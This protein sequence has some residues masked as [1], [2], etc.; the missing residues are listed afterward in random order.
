M[1]YT[2]NYTINLVPGGEMPVVNTSC[3]DTARTIAFTLMNGRQAAVI[4]SGVTATCDGTK[5]DNHSFTVPCTI[6]S[7]IINVALTE[8]M[9][10]IPGDVICQI[11]LHDGDDVIGTANF[12]LRVENAAVS[13]DADY[14][15]SY[16]QTLDQ[17][18]EAERDYTDAGL[19]RV[20]RAAA[21]YTDTSCAETLASAKRYTE[22]QCS[23]A[24][25]TAISHTDDAIAKQN[26]IRIYGGELPPV[27]TPQ[28]TVTIMGSIYPVSD[29]KNGDLILGGSTDAGAGYGTIAVL[30]DVTFDSNGNFESAVATPILNLALASVAD[31]AQCIPVTVIVTYGGVGSGGVL[32]DISCSHSAADVI[33]LY[34]AKRQ[35]RVWLGNGIYT[36]QPL[37][38][39]D[40]VLRFT[41]YNIDDHGYP[42]RVEVAFYADGTI[43]GVIDTPIL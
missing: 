8:Q 42:E 30:S 18:F 34:R 29:V 31:I 13:V 22:T 15:D 38:L 21:A 36:L 40:G 1:N 20:G 6:V 43:T 11:T 25:N 16:S 17:R 7:G 19:D 24:L 28:Q 27:Q 2:Q 23:D 35:V 39:Y 33:A 12:V 41:A 4:P 32:E 37:S 14:S 9:T 26:C 3:R 10:V 5:P